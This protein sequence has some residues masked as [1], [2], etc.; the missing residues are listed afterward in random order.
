M[1]GYTTESVV[2]TTELI[3]TRQHP[4]DRRQLAQTLHTI[5]TEV[6]RSAAVTASSTPLVQPAR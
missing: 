4:D 5:R 6:D 3:L 2:P 1:H